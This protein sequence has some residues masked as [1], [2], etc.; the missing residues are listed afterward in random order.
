MNRGMIQ[1]H[2][3]DD[4]DGKIWGIEGINL[5]FLLAGLLIGIGLALTLS[6]RHTPMFSIG[7][8]A[9]PFGIVA[10]YVLTLRQGKPKS[11]D[12]DLLESL[13][14]GNGWI[15]PAHQPRNPLI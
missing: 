12:T 1:T 9:V 4:S 7:A 8:G 13:A 6:G 2:A 3:G 5:L 15:P 14:T 11:Y 10:T